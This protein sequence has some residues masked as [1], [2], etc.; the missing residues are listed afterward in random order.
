MVYV[1][2]D[3]S[4][5]LGGKGVLFQS[6]CSQMNI[7][8]QKKTAILAFYIIL[9]L[10]FCNYIVNVLHYRGYDVNEMYQ[11]VKLLLLSEENITVPFGTYFMQIY[12]ILVVLPAG[13]SLAADRQLNTTTF[14][15]ARVGVKNY[16]IGKVIAAF[17]TAF[18]IFSVPLL[19]EVLLNYLSFPKGAMGNLLNM[20]IYSDEYTNIVK[21]YPFY[22]IYV[23]H[24]YLYAIGWICLVG[25]TGG[26]LNVI[27][28]AIST[29]RIPYKVL[30][31]LPV[32]FILQGMYWIGDLFHMK[33]SHFFFLRMF[34]IYQS[35][36]LIFYGTIFIL[37]LLANIIIGV[38]CWKD[39]II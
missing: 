15:S 22:K 24:P 37:F 13:F 33:L 20:N 6:I 35:G 1:V 7:M 5:H 27:T 10:V 19:L 26:M 38:R 8:L 31:F 25:G 30:L 28:I 14:L 3:S 21:H 12:P 34:P 4:F 16:F 29:F 23:T 17:F 36:Y 18:I 39:Y 11:P 9:G 2:Y 32:Y